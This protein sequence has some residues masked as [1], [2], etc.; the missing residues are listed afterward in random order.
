[1]TTDTATRNQLHA[2]LLDVERQHRAA[3]DTEKQIL[4]AAGERL[5]IV[6]AQIK[7]VL[8]CV[9]H[10]ESAADQYQALILERGQ[11][12]QT[13]ALARHTIAHG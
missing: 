4:N 7:T 8:P 3:I 9:L 5:K 6:Q 11:L 1:M 12:Q 10:D 2:Q 13:I